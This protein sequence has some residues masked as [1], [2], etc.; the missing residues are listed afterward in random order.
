[1]FARGW[2]QIAGPKE[3]YNNAANEIVVVDHSEQSVFVEGAVDE[4]QG[5]I[6]ETQEVCLETNGYVLFF[7]S[8]WRS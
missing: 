1:M 6:A 7:A 3:C 4:D 5:H 8:C 2:T